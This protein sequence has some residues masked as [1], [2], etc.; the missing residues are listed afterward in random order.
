MKNALRALAP[1]LL[2]AAGTLSAHAELTRI[3]IKSTKDVLGG[4][5]WGTTGAYK[6]LIGTAY[7]T[8]DPKA[9][10]NRAIPNIDKAPK[11]AQGLIEFSSDIY[12]DRPK[13]TSKGNGVAFFE[14][15][16]RGRRS[17]STTFSQPFRGKQSDEEAQYGDGTLFERGFTLVWVGWQ[18]SVDR[19]PGL[20]GIDLPIAM[21]NGKPVTG[22]INTFGI[23][24]PW[25]IL[26]DDP[27]L[28]LDPD[29]RRYTPVSL[30][31]PND[32]LQVAQGGFDKPTVI[33]RDQWSFSDVENGQPKSLTLKTGFKAGMRYDLIY[34][35][36]NTPVLGLG[37]TAQRDVASAF[38][39]KSGM[40]VTAKYEYFYGA[41]QT[42]RFLREYVYDGF[43]ADEQGRKTFDAI[44]PQI[45]GSARGDFINPF[46]LQ[47]GL[48]I[49][50]GSMFPYSDVPQKDPVT[51]KVDGLQM[52]MPA[53]VVPKILV[54]TNTD[55]ENTGGG[56]DTPLLTTALDG[57]T[58]LKLPGN[59][60]VYT[61]AGAQHGAAAF[62]PARGVLANLPNPNNYTWGMRAIFVAMDDM[63][64]KG[65][66]MPASLY[67]KFS[68]GTL[69]N[70]A[71]LKFP[72]IPG[73]QSPA[74][75][76]G[77]YMADH[78]D[79]FTAPKLPFLVPNVD[80]D[81]NDRAGLRLPEIAVPLAT[82]TGWNFRGPGT[83]SPT[84]IVPLQG[85]FFPF[86]LTKA[87]R[88]KTG[89]PRLSIAERYPSKD[90]Y[91]AKVKASADALVKGRYLL[92]EDVAPLVA[93]ESLVWDTLT[94][95]KTD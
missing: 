86:P 70:H 47:D 40:P 8:V 68:N 61:W 16:N 45:S 43:V 72:K 2:L 23:G 57:K 33:P 77:G 59:V 39:Y 46:A 17:L 89:D 82:Y 80:V 35:A 22:K 66:P 24:A 11:N 15:S 92:A 41:S 52:H 38:R 31:D 20:V 14:A 51:G 93:H 65:T 91:L 64:R 42:G 50:T 6:E 73:V 58:E 21:D 36:K 27:K 18:H 84:E 62:P 85:S 75:I 79:Q 5:A 1:A 29:T 49:F 74:V 48:G 94:G 76:P 3:E 12:I 7:F 32:V 60:R 30:D 95:A 54:Y 25:I 83:G 44:W 53:A 55:V 56:R 37:Y 90:A 81:G 63:V 34:T 19:K 28:V 10:A 9:A 13:D 67:S 78:G 4:K 26:K 88:E 87:E 71:D 69:V